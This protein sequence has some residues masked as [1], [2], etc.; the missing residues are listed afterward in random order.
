M[1]LA[2]GRCSLT[3]RRGLTR[4]PAGWGRLL[5]SRRL[6]GREVFATRDP[7]LGLLQRGCDS[8]SA[9]LNDDSSSETRGIGFPCGGCLARRG[10]A[11]FG[12][13]R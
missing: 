13:A 6:G 10:S 5:W 7:G 3:F 8:G 11:G 9:G 2:G 12:G 4:L 1:E